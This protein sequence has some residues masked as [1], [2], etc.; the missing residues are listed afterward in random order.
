MA[1]LVSFGARMS[2][3]TRRLIILLA[4]VS[5]LMFY[6]HQSKK[7]DLEYEPDY[8]VPD[9]A[10]I[11][12]KQVSELSDSSDSFESF[13]EIRS[14]LLKSPVVIFSKSYC[15]HSKFVK[16][17][18]SDRYK[19]DPPPLIKELDHDSHGQA[20]QDALE[21]ITG[22][23]TVPNVFVG[24]KSL[25]GGDEMRLLHGQNNLETAFQTGA[26]KRFTITKV[27]DH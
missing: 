8:E 2:R 20:L 26:G 6:L 23:R 11:H 27:T 22:R 25:G 15:P 24:G 10:A 18:L 1:R 4:L 14:M 9:F 7:S 19:M 12:G 17:L 21:T 3:S 16:T 5:T 13:S